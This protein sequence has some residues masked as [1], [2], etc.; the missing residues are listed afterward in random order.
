LDNTT[1][2]DEGSCGYPSI[3]TARS[4]VTNPSDIF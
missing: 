2:G 3:K 1:L 4:I